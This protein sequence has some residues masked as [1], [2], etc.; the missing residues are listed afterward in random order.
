MQA[1]IAARFYFIGIHSSKFYKYYFDKEHRDETL[2]KFFPLWPLKQK[3]SFMQYS[4]KESKWTRK[5]KEHYDYVKHYLNI[6]LDEYAYRFSK[7]HGLSK[8]AEWLEFDAPP[9]SIP[10]ARLS[11][12]TLPWKTLDIRF[13]RK[14]IVEGYRLQYMHMIRQNP[15]S[16]YVNTKR[17][18]PDF[19][20]KHFRL[21]L[22]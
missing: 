1:L 7:V 13:R 9:L 2:D 11:K 16:E 5:C 19:I 20:I 10:E 18:V 12:I 8:F 4:T 3:P 14:D 21:D 22:I 6:L 15:M 17:D